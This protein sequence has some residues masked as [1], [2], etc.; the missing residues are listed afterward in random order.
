ME[1]VEITKR[2]G[3]F[4]IVQRSSDGYINA[5]YIEK[6]LDNDYLAEVDASVRDIIEGPTTEKLIE[7]MKGTKMDDGVFYEE[8]DNGVMWISPA[9]LLPFAMQISPK[10]ELEVIEW[11]YES[12]MVNDL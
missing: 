9:L 6:Q 5:D 4:D 3:E 11:F 7:D 10:L 2:L 12:K 8:D 1:K